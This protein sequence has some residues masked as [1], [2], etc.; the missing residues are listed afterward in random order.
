MSDTSEHI[1][2]FHFNEY[3]RRYEFNIMA[4]TWKRDSYGLYDYE[5]KEPYKQNFKFDTSM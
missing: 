5:M 3:L 4:L 2:G 1:K